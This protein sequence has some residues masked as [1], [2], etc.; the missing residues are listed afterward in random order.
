VPSDVYASSSAFSRSARNSGWSANSTAM[1]RSAS[2]RICRAVSVPPS[3]FRSVS[4]KMLTR[5]SRA[6]VALSASCCANFS[7]FSASFRLF[8]ASLRAATRLPDSTASDTSASSTTP[9]SAASAGRRRAPPPRP[10][11]PPPPAPPPPPLPSPPPPPPGP[12]RARPPRREPPQVV[13]QLLGAGVTPR[14]LL[15]Q[16]LQADRLQVRRH[17]PAQARRRRRL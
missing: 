16:A 11:P 9:T 7:L 10:P 1:R 5:K 12:P 14:R 8:S 15:A 13:G 4:L 17:L 2:S 3:P 6:F